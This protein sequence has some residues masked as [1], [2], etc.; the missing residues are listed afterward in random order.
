MEI[1]VTLSE[2]QFARVYS[3]VVEE[4]DRWQRVQERF[5]S[6]SIEN[7]IDFVDGILDRLSDAETE[8]HEKGDEPDEVSNHFSHP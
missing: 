5:S 6:I 1:T 8:A 3:L 7:E 2:E 4:G